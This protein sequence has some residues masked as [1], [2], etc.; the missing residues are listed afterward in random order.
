MSSILF[1][2]IPPTL[3][4]NVCGYVFGYIDIDIYNLSFYCR[5]INMCT[6]K[7]FPDKSLLRPYF[8][9]GGLS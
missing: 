7:S 9:K 1:S 8:E 3:Y 6:K 2:V 4:I 5:S